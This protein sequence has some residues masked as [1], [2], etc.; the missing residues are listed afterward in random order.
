M[1]LKGRDSMK[2]KF[3]ILIAALMAVAALAIACG[4]S[5]GYGVG[6]NVNFFGSGS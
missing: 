1:T 6:G 4:K 3:V 5:G 2:K